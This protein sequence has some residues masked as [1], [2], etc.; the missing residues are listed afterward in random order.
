LKIEALLLLYYYY[1][2]Y[3]YYHY[4]LRMQE[5]TEIFMDI[6]LKNIVILWLWW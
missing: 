3:Y 1:Y 5:E 2:Y 6:L 4:C